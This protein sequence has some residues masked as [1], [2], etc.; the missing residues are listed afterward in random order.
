MDRY[1]SDG[2]SEPYCF[3]GLAP[4]AY[5]VVQNAPPGYEPSGQTE[6]S[7]AVGEETSLD[8]QFGNVRSESSLTPNQFERR[9]D[10]GGIDRDYAT[11]AKIGGVALVISA[12]GAIAVFVA[13]V[14]RKM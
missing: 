4:G 14:R 1:T 3:T 10:T 2:I 13:F 9:D 5:R 8:M 7:V 6:R 11:V 12:V